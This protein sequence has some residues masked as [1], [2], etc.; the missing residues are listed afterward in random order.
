[1]QADRQTDAQTDMLIA[2]VRT[3]PG[4]GNITY[5]KYYTGL[6]PLSREKKNPWLFQTKLQT[7]Y[8][9]NVHLLIQNVLVT[10]FWS[11]FS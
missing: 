8:W 11:R 5:H 2:T 3:P 7:T 1:M 4:G 9:T 10:K 6:L